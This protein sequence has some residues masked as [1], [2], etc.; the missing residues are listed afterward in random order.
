MR[1]CFGL[2]GLDSLRNLQ[3]HRN[4]IS[5]DGVLALVSLFVA[6][7]VRIETLCLGLNENISEEGIIKLCECLAI[8][9]GGKRLKCLHLNDI[10]LSEKAIQALGITVS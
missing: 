5:D 2:S 9:E 10:G 4:D 7:E 6:D 3:I 8:S 1:I